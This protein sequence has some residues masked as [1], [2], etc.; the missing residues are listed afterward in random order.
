MRRIITA[1]DQVQ[2]LGAWW[3]TAG[4]ADWKADNT[5]GFP[6]DL[7]T[8]ENGHRLNVGQSFLTPGAWGYNIYG[9]ATED[10]EWPEIA[11]SPVINVQGKE[12]HENLTREQARDAAEKHYERLFPIGTDTGKHD[13][14]V[15]YDDL[16]KFLRDS[17]RRFVAFDWK[18]T[19][20]H[21]LDWSDAKDQWWA[22]LENGHQLGVWGNPGQG[23]SAALDLPFDP[24]EPDEPMHEDTDFRWPVRDKNSGRMTKFPTREHAQRGAEQE[25]QKMF[26]IGTNTGGHDSG[27]DYSD[28]NK[29]M[30]EM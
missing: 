13:S 2:L 14:G 8:L 16:G 21:E 5:P 22:N 30:G 26:P 11:T 10:N 27:V 19:P 29:F 28:L 3:R 9:P 15:D 24:E 23:Y 18:Q 4:W 25:Y 6:T 17:S 12:R 20:E 1:R 7:A